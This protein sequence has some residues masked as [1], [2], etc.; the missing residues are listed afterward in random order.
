M[1][2]FVGDIGF[3]VLKVDSAG[4]EQWSKAFYDK[5]MNVNLGVAD[6]IVQ[7]SDEGYALVGGTS[8][9]SYL[10]KIDSDGNLQW[11]QYYS[12]VGE[13]SL[14]KTSDD[15]VLIAG[16]KGNDC[17][18]AKV[19]LAGE[20]QW[21]HSLEAG[22][23]NEG[24][25]LIQT[26]DGGYA[27][28]GSVNT[29][30]SKYNGLL[31]KT[32]SLGNLLWNK[33]YVIAAADSEFNTIIE[34]KDGSYILAGNSYGNSNRLSYMI[35]TD[36]EGNILWNQTYGMIQ[37]KVIWSVIQT[38]DLG[39]ALACGTYN[40]SAGSLVKT[41]ANGNLQWLLSC[42]S[43]VYAVAQANDGTFTLAGNNWLARTTASSV[44]PTPLGSQNP[45]N[46][47]NIFT[48]YDFILAAVLVVATI[49]VISVVTIIIL[50]KKKGKYF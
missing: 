50:K 19:N 11:R 34:S 16:N 6:S 32:D 15:A 48:E 44:S 18:L 17:W 28:A 31:I 41:D 13:P 14:I 40:E 7:T 20:M 27:I 29:G 2:I 36:L 23:I 8:N 25:T 37:D 22:K 42:N 10:Y 5:E 30:D 33:T 21:S 49:I 26:D 45:T 24:I 47:Q 9:Y 3:W 43:T 4:K 35:K 38:D 1:N 39:F 46:S 12:G